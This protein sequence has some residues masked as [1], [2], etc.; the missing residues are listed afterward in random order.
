VRTDVALSASGHGVI[1]AEAR[2]RVGH[3]QD[4]V[5]AMPII[6]LGGF[7]VAQLRDFAVERLEVAYGI[8]RTDP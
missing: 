3:R 4:I 5:R 8:G 1:A 7:Q 2:A 6:A